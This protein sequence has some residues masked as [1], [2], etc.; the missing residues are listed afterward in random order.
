MNN[1]EG[2]LTYDNASEFISNITLVSKEL[3]VSDIA[4]RSINYVGWIGLGMTNL[5]ILGMGGLFAYQANCAIMAFIPAVGALTGAACVIAMISTMLIVAGSID[6]VAGGVIGMGNSSGDVKQNDKR[7]QSGDLDEWSHYSNL[8]HWHTIMRKN[9]MNTELINDIKAKYYAVD[10]SLYG[11]NSTSV[12]IHPMG[13]KVH[14]QHGLKASR[15]FVGGLNNSSVVKRDSVDPYGNGF[16][17]EYF[18]N[19]AGFKGQWCHLYGS[20]ESVNPIYDWSAVNELVN[21]VTGGGATGQYGK[22]MFD[23]MDLNNGDN[24]IA[25]VEIEEEQRG[26][27]MN[28]EWSESDVCG[29]W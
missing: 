10:G 14:V 19:G 23:L 26:F 17:D 18:N 2:Y 4:K 20:E 12:M 6:T 27:G 28:E 21:D 5:G 1:F 3:T 11:I 13:V 7:D 15:M 16:N 9:G 22:W 8:T 29:G 24:Q 25:N